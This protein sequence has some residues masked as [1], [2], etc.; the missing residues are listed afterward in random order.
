[1]SLSFNPDMMKSI[2][3]VALVTL[4]ISLLSYA[5]K[6]QIGYNYDQWDL[7]VAGGYNTVYGDAE[8]QTYAPSIHFNLNYNQTPFL[9]YVFEVQTGQLKG[10]NEFKDTTGRQFSNSF[11]MF[12]F[13]VQIQ[14]GEIFDYSQSTFYNA[15]KNLYIAP[16]IGYIVNN[17]KTNRYSLKI[18]DFYTPGE[19][20]STEIVLPLRIGYEFKLF[21][22]MGEPS[23]KIDL[24][25]QYNIVFGDELDGFKTGRTNYDIYTQYTLGIKFAIGGGTSY[26][27]QIYY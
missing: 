25:Y 6:A 27:K 10:G 21:N 3:R 2:L 26:R 24:G 20:H 12:A 19:D 17:L 4:S 13:R 8:T 1:M 5:A 7:G 22:S 14:G 15:L 9:N 23:V 16:G 11:T 18:P